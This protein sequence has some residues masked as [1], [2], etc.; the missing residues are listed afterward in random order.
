MV[1]T[2][3]RTKAT[4]TQGYASDLRSFLSQLIG[5]NKEIS[6]LLKQGK[7]FSILEVLD[8]LNSKS[9]SFASRRFRS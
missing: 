6:R 3:D 2:V 9:G 7:G 8:T 4:L 5:V 1:S